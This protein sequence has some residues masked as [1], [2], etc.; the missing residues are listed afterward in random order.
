[1]TRMRPANVLILFSDEHRRDALGCDGH[2][3]GQDGPPGRAG[4]K[5]APGSPGRTRRRRSASPP[6]HRWRR[7]DTCTR[8]RCW[9]NAQ[10]YHGEPRGWGHVLQDHGIRV[11]SIGKLHYRG[12]DTN[13]GFDRE[14][15]PL[16][17]RDGVGW[18]KGLLRDHE[19]VLDCSHY[20]SDI[21]PGGEQLH[22]LRYRRHPGGVR[23]A[24]RPANRRQEQAPG[25]C[26]SP[27][28]VRTIPCV[29]RGRSTTSTPLDRMDR[30]R[31]TAAG[32]RSDHP[33][34]SALRRNFD[35]DRWFTDE[36]RQVARA[37][38]Y[39]LCSFLDH[40][41]GQVLEA[42]EEG[43]HADD[44]LVIYASDH[45]DHNGDRGLW[46]KMTP[47]RR[48][49]GHPDDRRGSGCPGGGDDFHADLAGGHPSHRLCPRSASRPTAPAS[50]GLPLQELAAGHHAGRTILSE[51]HDG[52]GTHGHVHAAN[53]AMEV[54]RVSGVRAGA[55]RHGERPV[56]VGRPGRGPRRRGRAGR[57]RAASPVAGGPGAGRT[58][59]RSPTRRR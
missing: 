46:T 10:A 18:V 27:G 58:G 36:T 21:G 30:A 15:L 9:S 20:A 23:V 12:S 5:G 56:R 55:L 28:C 22:R 32:E 16:H 14:I 6:G 13:N 59:G 7:A 4:G 29:V 34:T 51:Y 39:G 38:Y 45:G 1:M 24:P 50:S 57:V 25:P 8:P 53:A 11:E 19:A 47:V 52:G 54:Q 44:T 31:F 42:L 49:G 17:I 37:S 26:S 33:V 43:G 3:A 35:Y 2:P 41:V 48:V 40:Q